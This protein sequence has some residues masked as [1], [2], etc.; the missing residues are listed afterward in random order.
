MCVDGGCGGIECSGAHLR[1]GGTKPPALPKKQEVRNGS[2][3][4]ERSSRHAPALAG[5]ERPR[6]GAAS[7]TASL[8]LPWEEKFISR[9]RRGGGSGVLEVSEVRGRSAQPPEHSE[10]SEGRTLSGSDR[11]GPGRARRGSGAHRHRHRVGTGAGQR[12]RWERA[13]SEAVPFAGCSLPREPEGLRVPWE[14]EWQRGK[15]LEQRNIIIRW[16]SGS[17]RRQCHRF[18]G[19]SKQD[20]KKRKQTP[21]KAEV[22]NEGKQAPGPAYRGKCGPD[23]GPGDAEQHA[24]V[25]CGAPAEPPC[26]ARTPTR[27][28]GHP[29]LWVEPAFPRPSRAELSPH[30][31]R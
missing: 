2:L 29:A 19:K 7:D 18:C 24:W 3:G 8:P 21:P 26:P 13:A 30:G 11:A 5:R 31:K 1:A 6:A 9:R 25:W 4:T 28:G 14:M 27:R 23:T 15:G 12:R 20:Q 10:P 17:G 22:K 16:R